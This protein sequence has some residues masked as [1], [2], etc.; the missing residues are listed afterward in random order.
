VN[1]TTKGL[2]G[3]NLLNGVIQGKLLFSAM[4]STQ[5][6]LFSIQTVPDKKTAIVDVIVVT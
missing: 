6:N 1:F 2:S 4:L 3:N 5:L